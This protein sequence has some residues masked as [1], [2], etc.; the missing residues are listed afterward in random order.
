MSY[1]SDPL[2]IDDDNQERGERERLYAYGEARFRATLQAEG[3]DP[4]R[5][6]EEEKIDY[7]A[8]VIH[9]HRQEQREKQSSGQDSH[10]SA[11]T[12]RG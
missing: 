5:M 2:H 3:L 6:S 11:D 1:A 10:P 12:L 7:V 9:E 4:D 8:R